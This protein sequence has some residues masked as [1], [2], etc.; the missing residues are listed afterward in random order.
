MAQVPPPLPIEDI[1]VLP[2]SAGV[3]QFERPS[4]RRPDPERDPGSKDTKKRFWQ[5]WKS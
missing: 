3:D 1:P 2:L 5:F 4:E